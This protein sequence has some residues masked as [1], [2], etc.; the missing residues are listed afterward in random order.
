MSRVRD[1]CQ[2]MRTGELTKA[3]AVDCKWLADDIER[4]FM[5]DMGQVAGVV[6]ALFN[7]EITKPEFERQIR[8]LLNV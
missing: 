3:G 7:N 2:R 6:R 1:Y 8:E 5:E 4:K